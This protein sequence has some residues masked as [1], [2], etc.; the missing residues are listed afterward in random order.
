MTKNYVNE[1]EEEEEVGI[2]RREETEAA[3]RRQECP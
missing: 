2:M 3:I 1:K